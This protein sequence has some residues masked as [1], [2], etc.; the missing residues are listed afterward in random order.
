ML[1]LIALNNGIFI[2]ILLKLFG[3]IGGNGGYRDGPRIM[4]MF[5]LLLASI[6]IKLSVDD[7]DGFRG[8]VIGGPYGLN[9]VID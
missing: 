8:R 3:L 1:N 2:G 7:D 9:A 6:A 4:F 5:M